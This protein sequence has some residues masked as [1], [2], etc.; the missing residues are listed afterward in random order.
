[1]DHECKK[2]YLSFNPIFFSLASPERG[3]FSHEN[4]HQCFPGFLLIEQ[5]APYSLLQTMQICRCLLLESKTHF[6]DQL[7]KIKYSLINLSLE[8]SFI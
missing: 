6:S 3:I 1:M 8:D 5:M 7:F 4:V 2:K